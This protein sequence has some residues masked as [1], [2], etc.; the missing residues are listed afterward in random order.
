MEYLENGSSKRLIHLLKERHNLSECDRKFTSLIVKKTGYSYTTARQWLKEDALPRTTSDR[1][2]ASKELG[3]DLLYW[4]Y[5]IS[6]IEN[7]DAKDNIFSVSIA[8]SVMNI[9]QEKEIILSKKRIIEIELM[10]IEL[11]KL[12]SQPPEQSSIERLIDILINTDTN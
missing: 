4:E 11:F 3:I 7:N 10:A 12:N 9:I 5:G 1:I 6:K 8:N 2:K